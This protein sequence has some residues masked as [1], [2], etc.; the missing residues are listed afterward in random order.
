[1]HISLRESTPADRDFLM[2]VFESTRIDEFRAA[3]LDAPTI[4][5]LLSQQFSMQDAYYR[6]HYPNGRF[7]IVLVGDKA[8]GRLYHDWNAGSGEARV[9]DIALLPPWRGAGIGTRLMKAVLVE[10]ARR[11]MAVKLYVEFNNPVRALYRRLGFEGVGENGVYEAMRRAAVP[12]DDTDIEPVAGLAA[13]T[14]N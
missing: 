4:R 7:D 8:V 6:R 10:A 12:F 13:G 9:I 1:M 11:T 3:G 5:D 2:D 14:K